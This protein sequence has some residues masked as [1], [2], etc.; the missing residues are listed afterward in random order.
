MAL[1]QAEMGTELIDHLTPE[2]K[3]L[4]SRLNPEIEDLKKKLLA[5][6]TDRLEVRKEFFESQFMFP[7]FVLTAFYFHSWKQE[8]LR[9]RQ[10]WQPILRGRSKNWRLLYLRRRLI[11][12]KLTLN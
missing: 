7:I 2:E 1:K 11:H 5:F 9:L 8:K 3:E 4:L 10:N 6:K 12:C